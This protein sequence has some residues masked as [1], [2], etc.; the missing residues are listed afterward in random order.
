MRSKPMSPNR[1]Q[2][3]S[4]LY[5]FPKMPAYT[6]DVAAAIKIL[7]AVEL[8]LT[9]DGRFICLA[10]WDADVKLR[11]QEGDASPALSFDAVSLRGWI[12]DSLE[13][14]ATYEEWLDALHSLPE[15]EQSPTIR[16]ASRKAWVAAMIE[17][18]EKQL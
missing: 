12:S 16:L 9:N 8:N 3:M 1:K 4:E 10:V 18:L 2:D 15:D 14:A 13:E 6:G 5:P 7:K 17:Q 11:L